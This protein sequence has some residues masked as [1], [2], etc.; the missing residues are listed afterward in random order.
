MDPLSIKD[1]FVNIS[2]VLT[3][4]PVFELM[5]TG[6]VPNYFNT[7]VKKNAPWNLALFYETSQDILVKYQDEPERQYEVAVH[8]L[9]AQSQFSGLGKKLCILWETGNWPE[10]I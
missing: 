7:M 3:R 2:A 4:K 9:V 5:A 1:I 10:T 8:Q 6:N